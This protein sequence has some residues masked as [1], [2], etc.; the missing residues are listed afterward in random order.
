MSRRK[1]K[2]G[3]HENH[4]RWLV[5]YADF[6][7]LLFAFFTVL[8]ATSVVDLRKQEEFQESIKRSFAGFVGLTSG[9]GEFDT[10]NDSRSATLV[11][12]LLDGFPVIH[13]T[14]RDLQKQVED[15]LEDEIS[16]TPTGQDKV[17]QEVF[18]DTVGVRIQLASSKLFASGSSEL[19]TDS[20]AALDR[21][22]RVLKSTNRRLI[23]EGHTDDL[24]IQSSR[25]PSNW[26][27]SANRA[28]KI[29][30]YL[31]SRH[32][33][34]ASRLTAVAYADQKPVAP[35]DTEG[36]RGRNRRIEI[37]IVTSGSSGI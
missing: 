36:N 33:I 30:R 12:P 2:H 11:P 4:E 5:S 15:Q 32:D 9:G 28:T 26:E 35:N 24:P 37:L 25:F 21:L 23:I 10:V 22:G 20:A 19:L 14:A 6:I 34:P 18:H 29:V 1:N 31:M 8:Y 7:T 3:E 27:L 13:L 17:I 16:E